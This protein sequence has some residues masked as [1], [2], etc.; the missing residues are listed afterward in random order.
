MTITTNVTNPQSVRAVLT[1]SHHQSAAIST[2]SHVGLF[3]RYAQTIIGNVPE[4]YDALE[5]HGV[6][7][8]ANGFGIDAETCCEVDD[9]HPQF[10]SVYLH[11]KDDGGI[12]CA[13]DFGSYSDAQQYAQELSQ[14]YRWPI[15]DGVQAQFVLFAACHLLTIK[16]GDLVDCFP[17]S[18]GKTVFRM[19]APNG[20]KDGFFMDGRTLTRA[21]SDEFIRLLKRDKNELN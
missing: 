3:D 15:T 6:R 4:R 10:F 7:D 16:E 20:S 1:P 12:E 13:G 17:L 5:I 18:N 8:F 19:L 21:E 14:Q 11:L 9:V 2:R